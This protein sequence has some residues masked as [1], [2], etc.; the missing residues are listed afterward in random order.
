MDIRVGNGFDVHRFSENRD[1]VLGGVKIDYKYGLLGHSDADALVHAIIDSLMGP[2]GLGDIGTNFPDS[3][4]QYRGARSIDL[5]E[6]TAEMLRARKARILNIDSIIIC[7]APK[8]A[9]LVSAMKRNISQALD[10]L[11]EDRISIKGKTT[12]WLGFTGRGEGIAVYAVSLLQL[13]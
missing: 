7:Q 8:I 3:D 9:P 11:P 12:E 6:K 4:E 1:L 13:D 2:C 10:A 5:L